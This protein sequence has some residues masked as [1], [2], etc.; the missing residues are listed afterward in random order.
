[1]VEREREHERDQCHCYK[2][3]KERNVRCPNRAEYDSPFCAYHQN[4]K[5]NLM[6][7]AHPSVPVLI[8]SSSKS[9]SIKEA[10]AI[11]FFDYVDDEIITQICDQLV[12]QKRYQDLNLLIRVNSRFKN[13]C[14]GVLTKLHAT[15]DEKPPII[16]QHNGHWYRKEWHDSEGKLHRDWDAP[17][18]IERIG[19]Q[20]WY[21]HGQ[22]HRD[23]DQPA[24]ID[25]IQGYRWYQHGQLHR[26][27]DQPAVIDPNGSQS[28]YWHGQYHRDAGPAVVWFNG[29]RW[30]QHGQLHRVDGP[31]EIVRG[32]GG[33]QAWYLNGKKTKEIKKPT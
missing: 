13:V 27:G 15:L 20:Y 16:Y 28:W 24:V 32:P 18:V 23:H 1:M 25:P 22:L 10:E 11:S 2:S 33:W 9:P 8:R 3:L 12:M 4:C 7:T 26:E 5:P 29:E 21:L 30:Y 31:A 6:I 14:Q 19:G 17:A